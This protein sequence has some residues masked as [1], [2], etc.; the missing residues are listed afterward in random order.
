MAITEDVKGP[1]DYLAAV[2][3]RKFRLI[4]PAVIIVAI[5]IVVAVVTPAVYRSTGTVL[6]EEPEVPRE[7][8]RSTITSFAAERLQIIQQRVMTTQNLISII[9]KFNLYAERRKT[10]AINEIARGFRDKIAMQLVSAEVID[11]RSGQARKA[12]IAFNLSFEDSNR[13]VAQQVANELVSLYLN[14]NLRIR[15]EKAAETTGFLAEEGDRLGKQLGEL[16]ARIAEFKAR[17]S[18]VLPEQLGINQAALARTD[19]QLTDASRRLQLLEERRIVLQ[20]ELSQLNPMGTRVVDGQTILSPPERLKALQTKLISMRGVYGAQHPDVEKMQ[21]EIEVLKKETGGSVGANAYKQQLQEVND[22]LAAQRK[23]YGNK[24]P[25]VVKLERQ[26]QSLRAE[27]KAGKSGGGS[28][29]A[30]KPDNPNYIMVQGQLRT[31]DSQVD[32]INREREALKAALKHYEER[33]LK[34][35]ENE[36]EYLTLR[37]DYDNAQSKYRDVRAKQLEAQLAEA[38]ETERKGERFSLIEP[39][40]LPLDPIRPNRMAIIFIGLVFAGAA[41]VGNVFLAEALDESIY[42]AKSLR[43]ITGQAPLVVVPVIGESIKKPSKW[44]WILLG[45]TVLVV[46]LIG[47]IFAYHTYVRPLDVLWFSTLRKLGLG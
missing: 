28:N 23:K 24:H 5:A 37:R 19:A 30:P 32:A 42:G 22:L 10:T 1:R 46:C 41:G 27:I 18:G 39:P 34:I 4:V 7:F 33:V 20:S 31:L 36:R 43:A 2:L 44:P 40:Q 45:A 8:I 35:P 47:A 38:L 12:V 21:R 3:R 11:P 16:E 17:H 15:R 14:E 13:R 26:A 9:N 29:L 25:D 6:I